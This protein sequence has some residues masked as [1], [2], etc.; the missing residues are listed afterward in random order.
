MRKLD[1]LLATANYGLLE[2]TTYALQG[3]QIGFKVGSNYYQFA[4][5]TMNDTTDLTF[6]FRNGVL[7]P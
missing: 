5:T 3:A 1:Y 4:G 2:P 7:V 6:K